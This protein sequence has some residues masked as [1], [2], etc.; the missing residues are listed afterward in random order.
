MKVIHKMLKKSKKVSVATVK[1]FIISIFAVAAI[2]SQPLCAA[3]QT[4]HTIA[5]RFN[6][7]VHNF[8]KISIDSGAQKCQFVFTNVSSSPVAISNVLASC[9]CTVPSWSKAPIKPGEK[10]IIKVTF[11]NDQ[12]PYPFDKTLSVYT[13]ASQKP[14]MLRITGVVYEKDRPPR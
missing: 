7:V 8:G 13:T 11:L 6:E 9:G 3:A 10:G 4:G 12:G 14:I 2:M 1:L 5:L